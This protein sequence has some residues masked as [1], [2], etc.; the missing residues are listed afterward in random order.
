MISLSFFILLYRSFFQY[1]GSNQEVDLYMMLNYL[2]NYSFGE[3]FVVLTT[4]FI[5]IDH[6]LIIFNLF[7]EFETL[8]K[9]LIFHLKNNLNFLLNDFFYMRSYSVYNFWSHYMID[10]KWANHG[11][12]FI[13]VY[14]PVYILYYYT[15]KN[16]LTYFSMINNQYLIVKVSILFLIASSFR[17]NAIHEF[18]FIIKFFLILIILQLL[19]TFYKKF[20]N[21]IYYNG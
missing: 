3:F 12:S 10:N 20:R 7:V 8:T 13:M 18:G 5:F 11:F 16:I 4:L 14:W 17:G 15:L 19:T 21:K 2:I 1:F 9:F 6:N